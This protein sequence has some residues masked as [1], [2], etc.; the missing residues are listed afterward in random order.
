MVCA[1]NRWYEAKGSGSGAR[2]YNV[3][4]AF[5]FDY[6]GPIRPMARSSETGEFLFYDL[7]SGFTI[8]YGGEK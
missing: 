3:G 1:T 8:R 6:Q 4:E 5:A 2:V 7:G